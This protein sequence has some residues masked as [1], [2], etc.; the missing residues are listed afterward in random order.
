MGINPKLL[1]RLLQDRS[2]IYSP[3]KYMIE[4]YVK[5]KEKEL[6]KKK[7]KRKKIDCVVGG[8]KK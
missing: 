1:L 3:A 6:R 2:P 8:D 4:D 7:S 5:Q